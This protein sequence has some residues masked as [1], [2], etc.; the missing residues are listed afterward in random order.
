MNTISDV[1][2]SQFQRFIYESAGISLS[3]AKKALIMGRL[4]KRLSHFQ[5]DCFG[6][7]MALL[8]SGAH[9][10]EVQTAV[11]LL[12]TNETYFFREIKHF[13]YLRELVL[14]RRSNTQ[15]FRVWSAASSSGEEAYSVAMVLEDVMQGAPWEVIGTDISTRMLQDARRALYPM[16]R[17]R[18]IPEH[19]LKR[20]CRKGREEYSGKL[21]IERSLRDRV[22]FI[23]A[24][25]N[26]TLP[27]LGTFD[28]IFLR[29][30]MI[31]FDL[32]TK[33]QVVAR[34]LGKLGPKGVFLVGHSESLNDV[35]T[36]LTQ[37]APATYRRCQSA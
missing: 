2:L 29:N 19:Y 18:H 27:E 21:L 37:V 28:V 14:Q 10:N 34:V 30:V 15:V 25:L 24:N 6:D 9:P 11:D 33:R 31:Y 36:D 17:A 4:G 16:E 13:E 20:F 26:A 3:T 1:E 5:L 12:T 7:Y 23:H 35:T 8:R 22:Q 32:P